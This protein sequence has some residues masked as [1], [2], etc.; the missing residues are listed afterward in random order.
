MK[1]E[2][3]QELENLVK[4]AMQVPMC[5][6]N[7][8][9]TIL[10]VILEKVEEIRKSFPIKRYAIQVVEETNGN[11]VVAIGEDPKGMWMRYYD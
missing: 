3:V 8:I 6:Y 4:A 2:K 7:P 1:I 5:Q 9:K 10:E 11:Q